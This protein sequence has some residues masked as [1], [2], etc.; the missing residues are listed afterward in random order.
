MFHLK[1]VLQFLL[2]QLTFKLILKVDFHCSLI[3]KFRK[4][5][6]CDV[7]RKLQQPTTKIVAF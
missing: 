6:K 4:T 5:F 1:K 3:V 7:E 2:I